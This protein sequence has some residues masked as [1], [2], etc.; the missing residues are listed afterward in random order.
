MSVLAHRNPVGL[1]QESKHYGSLWSALLLVIILA[2]GP[3]VLGGA[4]TWILL[5]IYAAVGLL[6][7]LQALRLWLDQ[8]GPKQRFGDAIDFLVALFVGYAFVRYWGSEVGIAARIEIFNISMYAVVFWVCR[9]GLL[10]RNHQ[11][12][13]VGSM[14]LVAS[15]IT[16]FAY[17]LWRFPEWRPYGEELHLHYYPRLC[18]T[19]GCPNHYGYYAAVGAAAAA[20]VLF[21]SR[22]SWVWR[23]ACLYLM[24][25]MM[26][27]VLFSLSRGS[28]IALAAAGFALAIFAVRSGT[29]RWFWPV[30]GFALILIAGVLVVQRSPLLWQRVEMAVRYFEGIEGRQDKR[31]ITTYV[32]IQLAR[33]SAKIFNDYPVWGTG[34]ASFDLVH[35]RYQDY[36]YSTQAIYTHNDYLNSLTDYGLVGAGIILLFILLVSWR[37]LNFSPAMSGP[38]D[39]VVLGTAWA[40]WAAILLHSVVDFNMHIPGNALVVFALIGMGLSVSQSQQKRTLWLPAG[41]WNRPMAILTLLFCVAFVTAS[42]WTARAYYPYLHVKERAEELPYPESIG[43]L[44]VA[45]E[46]DPYND[47]IAQQLGHLYRVRAAQSR[48]AREF[49]QQLEFAAES[50]DWYRKAGDIAPMNDDY[51]L[52]RA[53]VHDMMLRHDEA[54]LMYQRAID[55]RPHNGYYR[56]LLGRHYLKRG[57]ADQAKATFMRGSKAAHGKQPNRQMLK[58]ID[59]V[60]KAQVKAAA[61]E[62]KRAERFKKRQEAARKAGEPIPEPPPEY[63]DPVTVP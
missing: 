36:D 62:K 15:G 23:I 13:I 47:S 44:K 19:Y 51:M 12:L 63:Y 49:D 39:L 57:L 5:P 4:R 22:A 25:L 18:G 58:A 50:A 33:D 16:I 27:G 31:D 40:A 28:W 35:Q 56:F 54:Y 53:Q 55:M 24:L 29:V 38:G 26:S 30:G 34:P 42:A 21:F 7:V 9:Y 20:A 14:I 52:L 17:F 59:R 61:A 8:P 6:L 11:L 2:T 1:R 32:R 46:A 3:I 41:W 45:A 10:S 48:S 37:L 43:I 60:E